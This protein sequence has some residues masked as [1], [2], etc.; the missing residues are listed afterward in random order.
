MRVLSIL[1][2][3]TLSKNAVV[4]MIGPKYGRKSNLNEIY[5]IALSRVLV[6]I[7]SGTEY[8]VAMKNSFDGDGEELSDSGITISPPYT[9]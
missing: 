2:F 6:T 7:K 1:L 4:K 5:L 3:A 8:S 9:H